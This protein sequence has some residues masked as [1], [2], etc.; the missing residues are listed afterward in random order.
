MRWPIRTQLMI[1]LFT[2]LLGVV[3]ITTWT[4][5]A[6]A[7][8]ARRQ[9]ENQVREIAR[10]LDEAEIPLNEVVLKYLRGLSGAELLFVGANGGQMSSFSEDGEPLP[11]FDPLPE[12]ADWSSVR[13][14]DPVGIRGR[15]YFS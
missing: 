12:S 10:T 8:R 4:A 15:M 3:G 6:S 7:G 1:P 2:L 5:L 11:L 13:M 9:V 14:G